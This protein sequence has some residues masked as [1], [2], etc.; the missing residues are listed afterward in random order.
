[1]GGR[2]RGGSRN[3]KRGGQSFFGHEVESQH[4]GGGLGVLP[5]KNFEIRWSESDSGGFLTKKLL[6]VCE[7]APS[8]IF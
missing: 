5:Q 3:V 4:V 7:T 6:L 8:H 1:M 2:S